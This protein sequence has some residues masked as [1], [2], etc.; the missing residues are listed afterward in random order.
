MALEPPPDKAIPTVGCGSL[1][2]IDNQ[3]SPEIRQMA[4]ISSCHQ[5]VWHF[6]SSHPIF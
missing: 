2:E 1:G 4:E 5:I 6:I 3:S